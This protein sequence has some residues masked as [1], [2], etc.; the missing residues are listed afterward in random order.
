MNKNK[1]DYSMNFNNS[2]IVNY[3]YNYNISP[4]TLT[5]NNYTKLR[6]KYDHLICNYLGQNMVVDVYDVLIAWE[7]S[8]PIMSHLVKKGLQCGGRG[9]KDRLTD[10]RDIR[11][12]IDR[13]IEQQLVNINKIKK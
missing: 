2:Y 9:H 1:S 3:N 4:T 8:C 7:V 5:T 13:A 12:S 6:N 11:S 10:L